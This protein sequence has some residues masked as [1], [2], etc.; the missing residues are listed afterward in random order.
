MGAKTHIK[1][2]SSLYGKK[3]KNFQKLPSYRVKCVTQT[4]HKLTGTKTELSAKE[5]IDV[6]RDFF[7]FKRVFRTN[8]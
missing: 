2:L 8:C 7:L 4:K 6:S 1:G 5:S 3:K